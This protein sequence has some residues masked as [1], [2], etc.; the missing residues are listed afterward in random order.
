MSS[1]CHRR[2]LTYAFSPYT[3][4]RERRDAGRILFSDVGILVHRL[5]ESRTALTSRPRKR[6]SAAVNP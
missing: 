3:V 6:A 4:C 1:S 2:S 5:L